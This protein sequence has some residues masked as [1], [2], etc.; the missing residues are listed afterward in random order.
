M[1]TTT[2]RS[3]DVPP[4]RTATTPARRAPGRI[5]T[6]IPAPVV[7]TDLPGAD[8]SGADAAHGVRQ[9]GE[10]RS[11]PIV[12][13][14]LFYPLWWVLGLGTLIFVMIAVVMTYMLIRYRVIQRIPVKLPPGFAW[15][16]L[17]LLTVCVSMFALNEN[18]AGTIPSTLTDRLLGAA[19]RIVSYVAITVIMVFVGNLSEKQLPKKKLIGLMAYLFGVTVAGGL[20]GMFAGKLQFTS[21]VELILPHHL[22]NNPFVQSLV[23][24]AAAQLMTV[25]GHLSPRPAAPWG[26]TNTWGDN[27][28][29]L[30]VWFL[31]YVFAYRTRY[32]WLAIGLLVLALVPAV[33]SLN[34]GMWVDLG[35]AMVW[36]VIVMVI[37]GKVW[38]IGAFGGLLALL[39][40]DYLVTPLGNVVSARLAHQKS[41]G[42]R[43]YL[44]EQA[45][46]GVVGSPIIGYGSTRNTSGG[47][48]SISVGSSAD[49]PRCG[50]FTIGG[51]GQ[52]WQVLYAHGVVGLI[53]YYG[54]FIFGL[55]RFRRDGTPIGLAGAAALVTSIVAGLWYN[56]LVTPLVFTFLAYALLWRNDIDR[57][58]ASAA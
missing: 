50:N 29:L 17:F 43:T 23:H 19:Y 52:V 15:W 27:L 49:C 7:P 18:P 33:Y 40:L 48:N 4:L 44:T 2:G 25:L 41:N 9:P 42:V 57:Q 31:V 22:R 21:P 20:L 14:L 35:A 47:R 10:L 55:F 56:S 13:L 11:W 53:T 1:G 45:V 6:A 5:G 32:K 28:G 36:I 54:F 34:R 30:L 12:G 58:T 37:R 3:V 24:P 38:I 46:T 16:V 26:Y 39:L 8:E 51:N